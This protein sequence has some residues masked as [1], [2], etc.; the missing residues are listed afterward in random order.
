MNLRLSGLDA[1]LSDLELVFNEGQLAGYFVG[2]AVGVLSEE[3][4][5]LEL[6]RQ[7]VHSLLILLGTVLQHFAHTDKDK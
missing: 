1:I 7:L 6:I 5:L 4:G 3:T 2:F